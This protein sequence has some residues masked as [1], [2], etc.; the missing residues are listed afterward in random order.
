[1]AVLRLLFALCFVS[2]TIVADSYAQSSVEASHA[3]DVLDGSFFGLDDTERD[4]DMVATEPNADVEPE[5]VEPTTPGAPER[6]PGHRHRHHSRPHRHHRHHRPRGALTSEEKLTQV[7]KALTTPNNRRERKLNDK[8]ARLTPENRQIL[9][10]VLTAR[11]ASMRLCC[12]LEGSERTQC[13]AD[14]TTQRYNRVCANQE[15]LC[16]WSVFRRQPAAAAAAET[17]TTTPSPVLERC[18]ALQ[19]TE[20]NQCFDT[21]GVRQMERYRRQHRQ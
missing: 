10:N 21:E 9:T 6:R 12:A 8:L 3:G 5:A 11:K 17:G 13:V 14:L 20:R 7:C 4:S 2:G 16:V 19:G 1:M 15:P 18:C